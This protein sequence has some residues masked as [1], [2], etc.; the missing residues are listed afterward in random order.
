MGLFICPNV[1]I[2]WL[3]TMICRRNVIILKFTYYYWGKYRWHHQQRES[4][5]K[6]RSKMSLKQM[7]EKV[8]STC[9]E[10]PDSSDEFLFKP[11]TGLIKYI[12][13]CRTDFATKKIMFHITQSP[14]SLRINFALVP[15][16]VSSNVG[17]CRTHFEISIL[18]WGKDRWKL[19]STYLPLIMGVSMQLKGC[20]KRQLILPCNKFRR[21]FTM[22]IY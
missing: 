4:G 9:S 1:S 8:F 13:R 5:F 18:Y 15:Q 10:F 21:R 16:L 7:C 19:Y 20:E 6:H 22:S 14:P 3:W 17:R 11:T 12:R 2:V